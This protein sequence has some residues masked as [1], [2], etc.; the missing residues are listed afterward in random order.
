MSVLSLVSQGASRSASIVMSYIMRE[1]RDQR[2]ARRAPLNEPPLF[3]S[4]LH[5][6]RR[7]RPLVHPNSY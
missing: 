7:A 1:L 5:V 4:S 3:E 6:L 2:R